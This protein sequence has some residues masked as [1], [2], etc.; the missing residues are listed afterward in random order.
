MNTIIRSIFEA[1]GLLLLAGIHYAPTDQVTVDYVLR[2]MHSDNYVTMLQ[3]SALLLWGLH[4]IFDGQSG[5]MLVKI[6]KG[7]DGGLGKLFSR[8]EKKGEAHARPEAS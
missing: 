4:L 5:P 8:K 6:D 1:A 3:V 7:G 2:W